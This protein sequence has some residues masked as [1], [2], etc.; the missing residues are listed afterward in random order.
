MN[1]RLNP[2]AIV[3]W[4]RS[5]TS[6]LLFYA[7]LI[8][9][10]ISQ[11]RGNKRDKIILQVVIYRVDITLVYYSVVWLCFFFCMVKNLAVQFFYLFGPPDLAYR[12][13]S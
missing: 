12:S 8:T 6:F 1:E 3:I 4:I 10:K 2:F 9:S 7:S 11:I 5:V 13:S